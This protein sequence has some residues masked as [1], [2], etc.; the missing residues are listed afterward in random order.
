M[1]EGGGTVLSVR[2]KASQHNFKLTETF[3]G[4]EVKSVAVHVVREL[5]FILASLFKEVFGNTAEVPR[6]CCI[7]GYSDRPSADTAVY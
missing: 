5:P 7:L 4:Q 6:E 2:G 1:L 3:L